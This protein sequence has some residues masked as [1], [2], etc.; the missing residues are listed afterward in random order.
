M[1][2]VAILAL[3]LAGCGERAAEVADSPG[4]RLEQAA[5]A[6]GLVVNASAMPLAGAW[7]RDT[8]RAC[9]AGAEGQAQRIGV[10]IDYGEG[11]GCSAAGSVRRSGARLAVDLGGGCRFD[12]AL[13]G[14]EMR[15]PAEL[16]Q[17]C[18]AACRGRA[19]LAAMAV[20]RLSA[21]A[22]EATSLRG[23]DGASLCGG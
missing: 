12:A 20:D 4:A 11:Q 1:R 13:E 23:S 15:F 6:E 8:D 21:S 19:S 18:E 7:G 3:L 5:I 2:R 22:S 17:A 9:V 10:R 16:P 14:E